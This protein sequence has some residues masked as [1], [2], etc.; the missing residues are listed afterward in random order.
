MFL[1]D[2]L[3]QATAPQI[4]PE[5]SMMSKSSPSR[6]GHLHVSSL[7]QHQPP[8]CSDQAQPLGHGTRPSAQKPRYV[9]H[10]S[11]SSGSQ[12]SVLRQVGPLHSRNKAQARPT[13]SQQYLLS[14]HDHFCG[15]VPHLHHGMS[16]P[17]RAATGM[18]EPDRAATNG[19]ESSGQNLAIWDDVKFRRRLATIHWFVNCSPT[20]LSA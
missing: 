7:L 12:C 17:D 20:L 8:C 1:D 13:A 18:S 14:S 2:R 5:M 16:E 3:L 6:Q 9:Q 10:H 15:A 11:R 19:E 4:I